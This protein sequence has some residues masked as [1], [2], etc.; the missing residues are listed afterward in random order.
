MPGLDPGIH[1][2]KSF[3]QRDGCAGPGCAKASPDFNCC[4]RRS[5]SEAGKPAHDEF[6][7]NYVA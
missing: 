6:S 4:G 7:K 1:Q 5:F 3:S 2:Q